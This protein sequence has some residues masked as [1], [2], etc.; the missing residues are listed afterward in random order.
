MLNFIKK[1]LPFVPFWIRCILLIVYESYFRLICRLREVYEYTIKTNSHTFHHPKKRILIY[2]IHGLG[3][4]GTEKILQT[5]ANNMCD[6]Y[7]VFFMYSGKSER[8]TY[9]DKRVSL[10]SF[11]FTKRVL[12]YPFYIEGMNPHI[13]NII[14]KN[15]I[16]LVITADSGYT[17]YPINT[18][19]DI[20]ILMVNIFGSPTL[21]KNITSSVFISKEVKNYSEKYTGPKKTN[22][23]V[24]LSV[25]NPPKEAISHAKQIREK[26]HIPENA[27]V[28]G[29][30]GRAS[31]DIF[32]PIAIEAFRRTLIEFPFIHYIIMSPPPLLEKIVYNEKIQNV[33]F[34]APSG[35][36]REI[37]GF[38]YAIDCL[39]HFRKDGETFG[40]NIAESMSVGNPILSHK[41]NQWNAHLE[42]LSPEFS[43]VADINNIEEYESNMKEFILIHTSNKDTWRKMRSSAQITANTLFTE[44]KYTENIKTILSTI[45][46]P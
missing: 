43:R 3:F 27:F 19:L 7:D 38:H 21:Q 32:D 35:D 39:A 12:S 24:Y 11:L 4:G 42:Y 9:L 14:H 16:D 29:R 40:L 44:K 31:D 34:I 22:R 17:Q 10:V 2:H 46:S 1:I 23:V 33:H 41:S 45:L 20:P 25:S 5:I 6:E 26:Y 28:F 15:Q 37:W 36:E 8:E 13:K 30:I 18:I